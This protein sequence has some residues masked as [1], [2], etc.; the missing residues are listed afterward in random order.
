MSSENKG[1]NAKPKAMMA[2]VARMSMERPPMRS[3][4]IAEMGMVRPKNTTPAIC[5]TRY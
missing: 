2:R 1:A 3:A 5:S 4:A